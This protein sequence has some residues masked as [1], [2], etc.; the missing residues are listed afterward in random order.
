MNACAG[1]CLR[2]CVHVHAHTCVYACVLNNLIVKEITM[3]LFHFRKILS[4]EEIYDPRI[5]TV[6]V[7]L[8]LK[9]IVYVSV[10]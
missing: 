7:F 2:A 4:F 5:E 6:S 1:V 3:S 8:T 10:S 9:L